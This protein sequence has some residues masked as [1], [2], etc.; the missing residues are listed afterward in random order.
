MKYE[1]ENTLNA[2]GKIGKSTKGSIFLGFFTQAL[3]NSIITGYFMY[4]G[5]DVLA[6]PAIALSNILLISKIF[7]G[8]TDIGMGVVIDKT[9]S[10]KGKARPWIL[11]SMIPFA[12]FCILLFAVPQS[13]SNGMKLVWLFVTYNLYALAYTALG[14]SMNTLNIRLT[15]DEKEVNTLSTIMIG[16][17]VTG[18]IVINFV[19]VKVL[20]ALSGSENFTQGGF[21]KL[22]I[23]LGI[24]SVFGGLATYL[25]T[26]EMKDRKTAGDHPEKNGTLAGLK[27]L[28]TNKYWVMQLINS[29]LIYFAL[30]C[31]LSAMIYYAQ[32][33]LGNKG[34]ISI[35][36]VAE[37]LPVLLV[38]PAALG[39]CNKYGKRRVSVIGLIGAILCYGFMILNLRN[40]PLFILG[41][42]VKG[43]CMA[44]IQSCS[45]AFIVDSAEYGE[46]KTGVRAEGMSFSAISFSQKVSAGLA[47]VVIGWV[48]T[49]TGYVAKASQQTAP[50]LNGII[51]LYIGVT[52]VCTIGQ[53][54]I[55]SFYNLDQKMP[56]IRAELSEQ[57]KEEKI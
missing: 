23:I 38:M 48:L 46:W 1:E 55:F 53:L 27:S 52:L 44:P 56:Q 9:K 47:N 8:I 22:T 32:Y 16:G 20:T 18:T 51:F 24:A 41:T 50:A 21:V 7:D 19:A 13:L 12:M 25:T 5:T 4:F 40:F 42:I 29:L 28:F 6:L 33:V 36:V 43:I 39:L 37:N 17:S 45:N 10:P 15:R 49:L 26:T 30:T 3:L 34:L 2:N 14:I 31:R 11:R 54:V 57:H 35:L